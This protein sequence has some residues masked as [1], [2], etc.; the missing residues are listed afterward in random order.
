MNGMDYIE[1][2]MSGGCRCNNIALIS[3]DWNSEMINRAGKAG[4]KVFEKPFKIFELNGWLDD[5][6]KKIASGRILSDWWKHK[7]K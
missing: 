4:I 3:G 6:E 2:Q 5:A 1:D 7:A